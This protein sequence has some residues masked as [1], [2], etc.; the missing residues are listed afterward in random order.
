MEQSANYQ[1]LGSGETIYIPLQPDGR[2]APSASPLLTY[3]G[4]YPYKP[5]GDTGNNDN[6]S[7]GEAKFPHRQTGPHVH[8]LTIS[9]GGDV[10]INDLGSDTTWIAERDGESG[11]RVVGNLESH[12][13]DTP[14]HSV[15]S[16]DGQ[17]LESCLSLRMWRIRWD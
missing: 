12:R 17:S 1:Q 13:G 2:F 3:P 4:P 7:R 14:R 6:D 16:Q 9:S 11:L 8:G 5:S 10:Y 15:L